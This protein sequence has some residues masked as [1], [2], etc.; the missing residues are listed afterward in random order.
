MNWFTVLTLNPKPTESSVQSPRLTYEPLSSNRISE[1]HTLIRDKHVRQYLCDGDVFSVDWCRE[2]VVHSRQLFERSGIGI[3]LVHHGQLQ[4]LMG[5]CGFLAIPSISDEPQ[6]VYALLERWTGQGYATEMARAA[7]E[8]A[9][10]NAGFSGFLASV[11]TVNAAS[12]QILKKLG[13]SHVE[14]Q[15]GAFGDM[16]IMRLEW[17]D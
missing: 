16:P 13:F 3:W 15:Q 7:I 2:Q 11:D 17:M 1:F 10:Q 6:L 9:R 14:T 12:L 8:E 5:F 4:H